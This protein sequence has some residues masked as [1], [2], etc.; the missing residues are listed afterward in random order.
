MKAR[1]QLWMQEYPNTPEARGYPFTGLENP[2]PA[3]KAA[4]QPPIDPS[5]LRFDPSK[6]IKM[7]PG[8]NGSG[9]DD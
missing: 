8:W 7:V 6:L 2:R 1:H 3:T 4:S 5:R 9:F